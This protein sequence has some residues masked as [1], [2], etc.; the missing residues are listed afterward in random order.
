MSAENPAVP[1]S[2]I[3][4]DSDLYDALTAGG[5]SGS[6]VRVTV[7]KTLG[8]SAVWRGVNLIA[9]DIGRHAFGV[10]KYVDASGEAKVPDRLHPA[11][12]VLRKPND[13]MTPFTFRQTLQAHALLSGNGY[14]YILRSKEDGAP[15]QLLPL[16]PERTW[17]VRYNG[18]LWYVTESCAPVPGKRRGARNWVKMPSTD[19][20][21]IKGLG[22][23]GL[24]GYPVIKILRETIGGAIAARD[25]GGRYFRNDAS[26][27]VVIEVP[28]GMPDKAIENLKKTWG[29]L[30][31]GF[32][33]AHE[34]AILRDGVKLATYSKASARDAQMLE[35][36]SFDAREVA[37]I[38]G[39]PAHKVGDPSRTA[40]NSLE[41]EN[42]GYREDTLNNWFVVWEQECDAKLL[43]EEQKASETHCH[44]FDPQPFA[45][46]PLAQ[47]AAFCSTMFNIG[48]MNQDETRGIFNMNPLPN[49][50][51][52]R[53]MVPVNLAPVP[54][55]VAQPDPAPDSNQQ[56]GTEGN[57]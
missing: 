52:K 45:G 18:E 28:A 36:R 5:K 37:N 27:G 4:D 19:V 23:D 53:Y 34:I 54:A 25:Y 16:D 42:A 20:L 13:Y 55:P 43:T 38:L 11:A 29:A 2:S 12:R 50:A 15:L 9:G 14:A 30:H 41:S 44:R 46:V 33:N 39:V 32:R 6:G 7:G 1:L 8:L 40:Y 26:P 31:R 21:H 17:P 47:L 57:P 35:S 10:Y 51:G 24:C 49:G 22:S 48:S 3:A 56:P